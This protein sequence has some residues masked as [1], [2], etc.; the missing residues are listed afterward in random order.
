MLIKVS[1]IDSLKMSSDAMF[2][3]HYIYCFFRLRTNKAYFHSYYDV[4]T[5]W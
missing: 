2:M 4:E 1:S 3:R 5:E